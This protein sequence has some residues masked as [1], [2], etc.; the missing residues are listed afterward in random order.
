MIKSFENDTFHLNEL[1]LTCSAGSE[2]ELFGHLAPTKRVLGLDLDL[3]VA[4]LLQLG[5]HEGGLVPPHLVSHRVLRSRDHDTGPGVAVLG[6]VFILEN[7]FKSFSTF[8]SLL[9]C[10][11][12]SMKNKTC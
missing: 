8:F 6:V 10:V 11:S 3:V 1:G 5:Q 2:T 12:C 9:T 7:I 4:L